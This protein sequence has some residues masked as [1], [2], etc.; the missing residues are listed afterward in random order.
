MTKKK[1]PYRMMKLRSGD[2]VIARIVGQT[3]KKLILE[4]P[5]QVKVGSV[6][7]SGM[8]KDVV[9]LRN[10]LQFSEG[11][12]AEIPL[13]WV[14]MFMKPD[15][16]I[17]YMYDNEKRKEDEFRKHLDEVENDEEAAKGV[18]ENFLKMI[19]ASKEQKAKEELEEKAN[20]FD[21]KNLIEPGSVMMNIAIPPEIFME[22]ISNGMLDNFDLGAMM[23]GEVE[24]DEDEDEYVDEGLSDKHT[25][26]ADGTNWTDWSPN[27]KDYLNEDSDDKE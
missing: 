6:L 5:M 4:R 2:E 24:E 1:T 9:L 11:D 18:L 10:W 20:K 12:R 8:R 17:V 16:D 25:P 14:A 21:P 26:N 22:I 13:D 19:T 7:E 27:V 23:G 15:D 3:K